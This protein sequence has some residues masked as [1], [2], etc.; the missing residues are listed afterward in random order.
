LNQTEP[1]KA[2]RLLRRAVSLATAVIYATLFFIAII[3]AGHL[4]GALLPEPPPTAVSLKLDHLSKHKDEYDTIFIG[5]SHVHRSINPEVFD[6]ETADLGLPTRSFNFGVRGMAGLETEFV[7]KKILAMKPERLRWVFL[8]TGHLS[9][10]IPESHLGTRRLISWHDLDSTW[11]ATRG[12]LMAD[13]ETLEQIL[14]IWKHWQAYLY[15]L[16]NLGS[17]RRWLQGETPT[18]RGVSA[19][20]Q[21]LGERHDGYQPLEKSSAASVRHTRFLQELDEYEKKVDD[22][23]KREIPTLPV[24]KF[25]SRYIMRLRDAVESYGAVPIFLITP[26]PS[27]GQIYIMQA[28]RE[29]LIP[30]LVRFD[31]PQKFPELFDVDTKFDASHP[32]EKGAMLLTRLLAKRLVAYAGDRQSP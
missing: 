26:N 23:I 28:D 17:V 18:N 31:D 8:E 6:Q 15:R 25:Q 5:T 30:H 4:L 27:K 20:E 11:T 19:P 14:E 22:L 9:P 12:L 10:Q 2:S 3:A 1:G 13:L 7:L 24:N 16:T 29:G 21:V 32:T